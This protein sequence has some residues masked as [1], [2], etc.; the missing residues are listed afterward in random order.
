MW[1]GEDGLL[2]SSSPELKLNLNIVLFSCH[3]KR[4]PL[5]IW[6]E[7]LQYT[8]IWDVKYRSILQLD[9]VWLVGK[10]NTILTFKKIR[11]CTF[12]WLGSFHWSLRIVR[13]QVLLLLHNH[14]SIF[15]TKIFILSLDNCKKKWTVELTKFCIIPESHASL[16]S[17]S[18]KKTSKAFI[19]C[20][21]ISYLMRK[22]MLQTFHLI[23][24]ICPWSCSSY[25]AYIYVHN[26]SISTCN[27]YAMLHIVLMFFHSMCKLKNDD[28]HCSDTTAIILHVGM[29]RAKMKSLK[30][31]FVWANAIFMSRKPG[32]F[33]F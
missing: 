25:K 31:W 3:Q 33:P 29:C 30:E 2:A 5:L 32:I 28:L 1:R 11:M 26:S 10:N 12:C 13:F 7:V 21:S 23:L 16:K 20:R 14:T 15:Y 27:A 19:H 18:K 24:F 9:S 22:K 6:S 4:L 8:C 17:Q